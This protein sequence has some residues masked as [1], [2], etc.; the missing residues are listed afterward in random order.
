MLR[1]TLGIAL[2]SL[3]LLGGAACKKTKE[4][5]TPPTQKV[6]V[7]SGQKRTPDR[8]AV[9]S[10]VLQIRKGTILFETGSDV[11][12]DESKT[13]LDEVAT[14]LSEQQ[15][16]KL[17]IEGHTDDAG[18]DESNLDLSTRRAAAVLSYL[19]TWG[20]ASDRLTSVGCGEKTPIADNTTEEGKTKNRRVAFVIQN[21]KTAEP[22]KVYGGTSAA[23]AKP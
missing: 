17:R 22:C 9:L 7:T 15:Q 23:A 5:K 21:S 6:A 10:D 19:T 18:T 1:N 8:I 4:V 13:L 14:I 3:T 12:T 2:L 11:I 20:I 16:L